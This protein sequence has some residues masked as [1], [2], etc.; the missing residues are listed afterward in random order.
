MNDFI[1]DTLLKHVFAVCS[2]V[3]LFQ[4]KW[5]RQKTAGN[6]LFR[7]LKLAFNSTPHP[8]FVVG[9]FLTVDAISLGIGSADRSNLAEDS[10]M[11]QISG[12]WR[13]SSPAADNPD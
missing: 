11:H 12:V 10:S 8:T 2:S 1:K 13:L 4:D 6:F 3:H 7:K 5:S 9:S